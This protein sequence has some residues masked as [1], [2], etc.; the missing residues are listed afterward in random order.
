LAAEVEHLAALA[1]R[2]TIVLPG[3][4]PAGPRPAWDAVA[5][6]P[7]VDVHTHAR[8]VDLGSEGQGLATVV[9]DRVDQG[10]ETVGAHALFLFDDEVPVV[11]G[12]PDGLID[13]T[14]AVHAAGDGST[15]LPGL[16]AAG[17]VR[18]GSL[19]Y[20]VA[21][22]ADGRRAAAAAAAFLA[23]RARD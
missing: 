7:N 22:A 3:D 23:E 5:E 10:T 21:A 15:V 12:L 18:V 11:P 8:I 9:I 13:A 14:G 2:V 17:G 4:R 19:P 1:E 16:F 6:L 20:L